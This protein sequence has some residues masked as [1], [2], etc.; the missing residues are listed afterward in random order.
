[1]E[2]EP[3]LGTDDGFALIRYVRMLVRDP[4]GVN[5]I[6]QADAYPTEPYPGT[7]YF[8]DNRY[9]LWNARKKAWETLSPGL[10]DDYIVEVLRRDGRARGI[11]ALIDFIILGIQDGGATQI[12]AGAE[13]VTL[14]SPR[15]RLEFLKEKKRILLSQT[16][17]GGGRICKT[18]R[19]A[20]GG[21]REEW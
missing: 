3:S 11:I 14:L 19:R 16:G 4:A 2:A 21:V 20:I 6:V 13:S 10:S 8:I 12:S 9:Q 1:M 17:L 5:N 15:E 18:R 7:A